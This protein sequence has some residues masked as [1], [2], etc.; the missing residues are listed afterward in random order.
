MAAFKGLVDSGGACGT[1]NPLIK[2]S[3]HYSQDHAKRDQAF[4]K[5]GKALISCLET[6]QHI[7]KCYL[8]Y[9]FNA[10]KLPFFQT[11]AA[12]FWARQSRVPAPLTWKALSGGSTAFQAKRQTKPGLF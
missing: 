7:L 2:L 3:Q 9:L 1:G 6:L 11:S 10:L 5:N 12:S 4:R 8:T